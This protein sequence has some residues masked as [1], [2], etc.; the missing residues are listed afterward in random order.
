MRLVQ[1]VE[2]KFPDKLHF[3]V[4][5]DDGGNVIDLSHIVSSAIDYIRGGDYLSDLVNAYLETSPSSI[6]GADIE[7]RAPITGMD[8]VYF[9]F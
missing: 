9:W 3:G 7:L 8:K 5:L 4:E 2:S 1:F 6:Y